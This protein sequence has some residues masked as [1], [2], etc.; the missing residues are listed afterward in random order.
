MCFFYTKALSIIHSILFCDFCTMHWLFGCSSVSLTS[1]HSCSPY[2]SLDVH[3]LFTNLHSLFLDMWFDI[4]L[5]INNF[6]LRLTGDK[7]CHRMAFPFLVIVHYYSKQ[8]G[9]F[10]YPTLIFFGKSFPFLWL[11]SIINTVFE[12]FATSPV[13]SRSVLSASSSS[14]LITTY[15][16][17][18]WQPELVSSE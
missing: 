3:K 18:S 4:I 14:C 7:L 8:L 12:G 2:L 15:S 1:V 6:W 16:T 13:G 9:R 5:T 11:L 17:L 10:W